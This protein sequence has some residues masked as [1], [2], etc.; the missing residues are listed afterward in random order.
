MGYPTFRPYPQARYA[1]IF[2]TQHSGKS[3]EAYESTSQ[4]LMELVSDMEGFLGIESVRDEN[5][6]GISVSYWTTV[7]AIENWRKQPTHLEAQRNGK[8]LWYSSF[9]T[10][11]CQIERESFHPPV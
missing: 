9:S 4:K 3:R 11:V 8:N 6:M 2:C 5:G 7:E 1:V 10:R